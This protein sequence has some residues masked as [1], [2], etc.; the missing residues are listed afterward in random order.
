[1][2]RDQDNQLL[3]TATADQMGTLDH[4]R[5]LCNYDEAPYQITVVGMTKS[6]VMKLSMYDGRLGQRE[7][8][9]VRRDGTY[10]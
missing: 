6:G 8:I 7:V 1:M 5:D 4:L 3:K 10:A 9:R 2:T